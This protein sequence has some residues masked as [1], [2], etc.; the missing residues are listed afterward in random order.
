MIAVGVFEI[1]AA[2]VLMMPLGLVPALTLLAA[3]GLGLITLATAIVH[4][5]RHESPISNV[6]L[7]LL[8]LLFAVGRWM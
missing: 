3:V 2:L 5:R 8:V 6:A 1:C 7:F 4:M